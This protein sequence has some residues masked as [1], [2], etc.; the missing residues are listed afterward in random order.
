MIY[1]FLETADGMW[2]LVVMCVYI[3][4]GSCLRGSEDGLLTAC[5][6]DP[7]IDGLF[8][9]Q[10]TI[11]IALSNATSFLG[12]VKKLRDMNPDALCGTELY[13]GFLMRYVRNSTAYLGKTEDC[14]D[15]DITYYRAHDPNKPR[16]NE[17]VLEEIEQMALFKYQ[18]LPHWGKNRNLAFLGVSQKYGSRVGKFVE[19]MKRF[20]PEGLFSSEWS[21]AML[22]LDTTSLVIQRKGCALEG[23]CICSLDEHCAPDQGYYCKPGMVYAE[24]RVCRKANDS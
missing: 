5:G 6:W 1:V 2:F 14:L 11:S 20:D 15:I 18:G 10:T 16:L 4:I 17:G 12:D 8:F 24:A 3:C 9:H 22:G 7:R 13:S 23:L 19:V 21:D